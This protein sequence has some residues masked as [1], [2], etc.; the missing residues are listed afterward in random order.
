MLLF[1]VSVFSKMFD[2]IILP[3][4]A[5]NF[6]LN[7]PEIQETNSIAL[8]CRERVSHA[9]GEYTGHLRHGNSKGGTRG[10][11]KHHNDCKRGVRNM[12]E[13]TWALEGGN[14]PNKA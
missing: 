2:V 5:F 10:R 3:V 4:A 8:D 9:R 6:K 13:R 11:C 12:R 14:V 7:P 1:H